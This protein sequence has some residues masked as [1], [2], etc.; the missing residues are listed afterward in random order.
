MFFEVAVLAFILITPGCSFSGKTAQS[1]K[2]SSSVTSTRSSLVALSNIC[3][4]LRGHVQF[5]KH[6]PRHNLG[7]A[8]LRQ[9]RDGTSDQDRSCESQPPAALISM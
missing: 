8:V 7:C 9:H 5:P 6:G 1:P 3:R 2:S 4:R